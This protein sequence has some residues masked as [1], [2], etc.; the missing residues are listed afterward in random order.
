MT[1]ID[2]AL[3]EAAA[4]YDKHYAPAQPLFLR[5]GD[6]IFLGN[7]NERLCRFCGLGEQD[8]TFKDEAH[9]IPE[10]LGNKSLFSYYECDACNNFFGKGIENDLG[11]WSKPSR[12]FSR[13]RGKKGVPS[14]K[15]GGEKPGWRIDYELTGFVIKQYED[16]PLMIV[17]E[18]NK[19][20]TFELKRDAY[21]PVAVLKAFVKIGL[22]VLPSEE[23][24]N[25]TE[26]MNWIRE[27]DHSKGLVHEFPLIRS[28]QPG[29]MPNDLIVLMLFRRRRDVTGVPYAFLVL[30]FGN[31]VFQ[32]FLPS[33]KQDAAINGVKLNLPPFPVPGSVD[34]A[35]YGNTTV[36][37]VDL[38]G[39]TVVR[40]ETVP[41]AMGF[42]NF[43]RNE[44]E[45]DAKSS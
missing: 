42:E 37:V 11:N 3:I 12:T 5:P 34:R 26:A 21:T 39:R 9:A 10:A 8:V 7:K 15:K 1:N 19:T 35:K 6:K 4:F 16:D 20:I 22:T 36:A 13:I 25:F 44:P 38:T 45:A 27:A 32:V 40:G 30:S 24:S 33:P 17:D 28:F 29:P 23:L 43:T 2:P 18:A 41:Y 14:L 31:E